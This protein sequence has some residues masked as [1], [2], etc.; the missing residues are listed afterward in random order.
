MMLSSTDDTEFVRRVSDQGVRSYLRKPVFHTD[1]LDSILEIMGSGPSSARPV[2]VTEVG[3]I[4]LWGK[5][6]LLVEDNEIN[7]KVALGL[8]A[9]TGCTYQ[10]A[11]N[12]EEAIQRVGEERFDL[13][14]MDLQMPVMGGIQATERIRALEDTSQAR[15]P[16]VG[17]GANAMQGVREECL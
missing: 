10:T 8:L 9:E 17:L 5:R 1:L 3:H 15:V 12:G 4:D 14:L 7:R 16:I 11:A 13:V 6:I 2:S